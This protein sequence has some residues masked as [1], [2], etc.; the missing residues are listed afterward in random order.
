M[1]PSKLKQPRPPVTIA[2][3]LY[4][5][6]L[7]TASITDDLA[8]AFGRDKAD[9]IATTWRQYQLEYT[10][11]LAAMASGGGGGGD[12]TDAVPAHLPFDRIT[13]AALV[14]AATEAG[15]PRD[16]VDAR[17]DAL[18]RAY[19]GLTTFADV[20]PALQALRARRHRDAGGPRVDAVVF[21]NGTPAML[22]RSVA[23]SP[24]LRLFHP[25]AGEEDK[26][27]KEEEEEEDVKV[28][29]KTEDGEGDHDD[30]ST[31]LFR[32]L[33]SVDGVGRYKPAR[34][35]YEFLLR[36]A[37]PGADYK[38]QAAVWLVTAN[39][40]DV[41]GARAAWLRVA[42][43]DRAGTGWVDRLG[44]VITE[45]GRAKRDLTPTIVVKG[46]DEA[47][48]KILEVGV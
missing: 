8:D 35:A 27:K 17:A 2:F 12:S 7:S 37:V 39:P 42:W 14:H 18:V 46:V 45:S 15:L 36:E 9:Q 19:D 10:W 48:E 23:T 43:V 44:D 1:A 26:V 40:F 38:E 31:G 28:K 20:L 5:T 32:K 24:T 21:S 29:V 25:G 30:Q 22:A 41:V 4:G 3:D 13:R 11:R 33:I 47:V 34:E 6:L 16:A